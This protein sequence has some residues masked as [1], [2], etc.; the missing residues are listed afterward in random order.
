MAARVGVVSGRAVAQVSVLPSL[1]TDAAVSARRLATLVGHLDAPGADAAHSLPA[2]QRLQLGQVAVVEPQVPDAAAVEL[3]PA[4][5][6]QR[7]RQPVAVRRPADVQRRP[8]V[9]RAV[10]AAGRQ[11]VLVALL[12]DGEVQAAPVAVDADVVR[13]AVADAG[14]D[15]EALRRAAEVEHGV[16]VAVVQFHREEVRPTQPPTGHH[17]DTVTLDRLEA[18]PNSAALCRRPV[19]QTQV[20]P[21]GHSC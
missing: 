10:V 9:E 5:R 17:H 18:E 12:V 1:A 20:R 13:S 21:V 15:E 6:V 16:E 19:R 8:D 14:A 7:P 3:G 2:P 11:V 4:A